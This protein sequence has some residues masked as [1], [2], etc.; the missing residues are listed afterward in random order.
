[1]CGKSEVEREGKSIVLAFF[2]VVAIK[3][4]LST[5]AAAKVQNKSEREPRSDLFFQ[6]CDIVYLTRSSVSSR[7]RR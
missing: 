3:S 2:L 5:F 6:H 4:N 7:R 1:L